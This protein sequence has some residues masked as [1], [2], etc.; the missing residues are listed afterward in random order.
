MVVSHWTCGDHAS[1][2]ALGVRI[3][4]S[5]HAASLDFSQQEVQQVVRKLQL[6]FVGGGLNSAV[7]RAHAVASQMDGVWELVAGAFSRDADVNRSTGERWSL[8]DDRVH[9]SIDDFVRSESGR[10][11]AV[12][13]LTPT[14]RHHDD[15]SLLV[16]NG[17]D[18]I[19][20]KA[21]AMSSESAQTLGD[22]ATTRGRA[23]AVTYNY[24]GYPM[25][26]ELRARMRAGELG[27]I[28][29]AHVEMPQEGFLRLTPEG[30]PM[31]PQQ[32]RREDGNVP[33]L[34]LDLGTHT[35]SLLQF[36]L[37]AD[38][39]EVV[40]ARA[41]HGRIAAVADYVSCLARYPDDVDVNMWYGKCAIGHRNG[42]R[43][44]VY[45]ELGAAEWL[46]T[47]PEELRMADA[48]ANVRLVDRVSP[49]TLVAADQRYE[50]FKV[51]HPAGFIEAFANLYCD[52][53]ERTRPT[54]A[55][56]F[57]E[58][59]LFGADEA[60]AGLRMLEAIERSARTNEWCSVS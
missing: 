45:G 57:D 44:R 26:R 32:W 30:N 6:G 60:A 22:L 21:L 59:F 12:V 3:T 27:R 50:R 25:V 52:V 4:D 48:Y 58:A 56:G 42:L 46:Q 54:G 43:V 11:D 34:S 36:L 55:P 41:H 53:A 24:T 20:E 23:L 16:S 10:L 38:P 29:A 37:G 5:V 15:V 47:A 49:G 28:I 8:A 18:V 51:G 7:G 13:V 39:V 14:P 19:C 35:H 9:A 40:A 33:T 2:N 17:F 1:R 31:Q